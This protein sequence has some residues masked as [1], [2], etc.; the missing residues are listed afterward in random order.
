MIISRHGSH[1]KARPCSFMGAQQAEHR[2]FIGFMVALPTET[3]LFSYQTHDRAPGHVAVPAIVQFNIRKPEGSDCDAYRDDGFHGKSLR[4][5][6]WL[7][8][9]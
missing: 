7:A 1:W 2:G 5:L 4:H 3:A 9:P 8:R 6:S